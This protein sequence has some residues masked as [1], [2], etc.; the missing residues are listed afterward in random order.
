MFQQILV[1]VDGSDTANLALKAAAKLAKEQ[2]SKLFI[3]HVYDET[4]FSFTSRYPNAVELQRG[5]I[6]EGK[7]I[8]LVAK[9][10]TEQFGINVETVFLE[11]LK[12]ISRALAEYAEKLP[13]D[14][15][16][17]GT[18]GRRGL[19]RLLLGSVAEKL[20]RLSSVPVLLIPSKKSI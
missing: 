10:T 13:A 20:V 1:A 5:F 4:A 7:N 17:I 9:K 15:I 19:D 2:N 18:H 16:V 11:S 14:I 6:D 8:L 3:V 12:G